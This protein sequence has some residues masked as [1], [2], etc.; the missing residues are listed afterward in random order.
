MMVGS[1]RSLLFFC[2]SEHDSR[3]ALDRNWPWEPAMG[4]SPVSGFGGS[5]SRSL[6]NIFLKLLL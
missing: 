3:I 6:F 5:W 4:A 1:K 2:R